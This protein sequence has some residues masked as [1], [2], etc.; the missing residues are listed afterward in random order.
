[1]ASARSHL[2][3]PLPR[4][5]GFPY[6]STRVISALYHIILLPAGEVEAE[7]LRLTR[8]QSLANQLSSC[9]VL[10]SD[11]A[12][13][14]EPDGRTVLSNEPPWGGNTIAG[15]L[16][17]AVDCDDGS[18]DFRARK[19]RLADTIDRARRGAVHILGDLTK[20]GRT[21]TDQE[22]KSL[23][24][25]M[26]DGTPRGLSHCLDCGDWKGVCLDPSEQF[27]G[28][29]MT[30]HCYCDNNNLCA[31][32]GEQLFERGLNANF[33]NPRDRRI[34]HVPGFCGLSHRCQARARSRGRAQ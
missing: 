24:G 6:I 19:K 34:W 22:K 16:V 8:Q 26:H 15:G 11:R 13:Y 17:P 20:G 21:A 30:V 1:M 33:Y 31:R 2:R 5:D 12:I 7:L 10:A 32:C 3:Q 23:A 25:D 9:L 27:R 14:C 18:E 29:V 4:F 28:Q